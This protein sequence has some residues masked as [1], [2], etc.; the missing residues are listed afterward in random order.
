MAI[1]TLAMSDKSVNAAGNSVYPRVAKFLV[2]RIQVRKSQETEAKDVEKVKKA[3]MKDYAYGGT[4]TFARTSYR[5]DTQGGTEDQNIWKHVETW[6][7]DRRDAKIRRGEAEG[8]TFRSVLAFVSWTYRND[9]VYPIRWASIIRSDDEREFERILSRYSAD[10]EPD[11]DQVRSWLNR[12]GRFT[13]PVKKLIERGE[14]EELI[15]HVIQRWASEDPATWH[16]STLSSRNRSALF[17]VK[18]VLWVVNSGIR[19]AMT[20]LHQTRGA[21]ISNVKLTTESGRVFDLV[22]SGKKSDK[23]PSEEDGTWEIWR[24]EFSLSGPNGEEIEFKSVIEW[25]NESRRKVCK[26]HEGYWTHGEP[27]A[28]QPWGYLSDGAEDGDEDEIL[29]RLSGVPIHFQRRSSQDTW[30]FP[31]R[32]RHP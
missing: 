21:A 17:Q 5:I 13:S 32:P 10:F 30:W 22:M 8:G 27:A 31:K 7:E 16:E 19:G 28:R 23:I 4:G 11:R 6:S 9:F 12:G 15:D 14:V 1:C 25:I 18:P 3:L 26:D 29:T 20:S 2:D 24:G